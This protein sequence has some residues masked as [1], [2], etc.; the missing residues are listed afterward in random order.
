MVPAKRHQILANV[1][2]AVTSYKPAR[3][4]RSPDKGLLVIP[5]V[6]T[7]R[8]GGRAFAHAGQSLFNALPSDVRLASSFDIFKCRIKMHLFRAAYSDINFSC[9]GKLM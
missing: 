7:S 4:L 2:Y 8:Y 1:Q 6:R 3:S 5:K 9:L